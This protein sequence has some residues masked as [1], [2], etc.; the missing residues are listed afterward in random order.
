[1]DKK[2]EFKIFV[3]DHPRLLKYIKD[4]SMTWQKYYEIYDMYGDSN[5]A[6]K[7]YL[8]EKTTTTTSAIGV[9]EVMNWLKTIDLDSIQN[10][11]SS[12]QRVLSVFQDLG[13]KEEKPNKN[14][15]YKPRPLYKH[16]ED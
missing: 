8:I 16:F 3:K 5:E 10:G 12:I 7:D 6:W 14:N 11:V 13:N 1:M 15:N 9:N 4:G 2:E